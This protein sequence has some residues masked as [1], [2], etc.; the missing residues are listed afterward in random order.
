MKVLIL[1]ALVATT[2]AG[3]IPGPDDFKEIAESADADSKQKEPFDAVQ[4][5]AI[6]IK[7][8][9]A[10]LLK[11]AM[12]LAKQWKEAAK[13]SEITRSWWFDFLHTL[14]KW[15]SYLEWKEPR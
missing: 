13:K 2:L 15:S 9:D 14:D 8:L 12:S 10:A 7:F 4:A 5:Y 3:M 1:C 11:S 6:A